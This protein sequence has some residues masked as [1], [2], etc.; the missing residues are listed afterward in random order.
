MATKLTKG[1]HLQR[2]KEVIVGFFFFLSD[3]IIVYAGIYIRKIMELLSK[4]RKAGGYK[5]NIQVNCISILANNWTL[6]FF[7]NYHS[8]IEICN[9]WGSI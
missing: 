9:S 1:I 2:K 6:K 3:N 4:Y 7:L 8:S 5:I